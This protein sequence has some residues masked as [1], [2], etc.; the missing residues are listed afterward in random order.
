MP[1][2]TNIFPFIQES[3]K[4]YLVE[5]RTP[6]NSLQ[7]CELGDQLLK[8]D[9]IKIEVAKDYFESLGFKHTSIDINGKHK[10]LPLDLA[11]PI[12]NK[13][14]INT[15]DIITNLGTSEHV[16]N[17]YECFKN[18]HYLCKKGGLFIHASP[19]VGSW[20]GHCK[21]HYPPM[22]FIRLALACN[23]RTINWNVI[24]VSREKTRDT[25][26]ALVKSEDNEFMSKEG[27]K[28]LEKL[29]V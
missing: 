21:Y 22:F 3:L 17:Q 23:Y 24:R 12:R 8:V 2:T 4:I 9:G 29:L 15:F 13:T 20:I 25:C 19:A 28:R 18:I 10:A 11:K 26:V 27:F 5:S 6:I 7:M 16:E 1:I 14:L